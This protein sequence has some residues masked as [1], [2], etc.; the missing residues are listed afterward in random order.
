MIKDWTKIKT[1]GIQ[2]KKGAKQ[3][4]PEQ[5]DRESNNAKVNRMEMPVVK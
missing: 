3:G 4:D 5:T 2:I 1:R